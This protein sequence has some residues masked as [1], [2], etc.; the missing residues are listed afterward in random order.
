MTKDE[1]PSIADLIQPTLNALNKLGGIAGTFMIDEAV[2][3]DLKC[4]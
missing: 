4:E 2:I 1:I 3:E